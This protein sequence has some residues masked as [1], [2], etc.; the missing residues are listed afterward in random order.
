MMFRNKLDKPTLHIFLMWLLVI[1]RRTVKRRVVMTSTSSSDSE[2]SN[3]DDMNMRM[4]FFRP[5]SLLTLLEIT[6]FSANDVN[7]ECTNKGFIF[8]F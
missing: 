6:E 1:T 7:F 2:R 5:S 4:F 3:S 8:K